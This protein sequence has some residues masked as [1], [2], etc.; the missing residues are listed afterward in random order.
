MN[1][2]VFYLRYAITALIAYLSLDDVGPLAGLIVFVVAN[3][4]WT[5]AQEELT[6]RYNKKQ[7]AKWRSEQEQGF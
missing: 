6:G 4:L 3:A 2:T 7:T 5:V 1:N